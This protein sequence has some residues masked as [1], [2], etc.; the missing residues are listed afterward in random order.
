[1]T[2]TNPAHFSNTTVCVRLIAGGQVVSGATM[3]ATAH[4][5]TKDTDLGTAIT[6]ADGVAHTTF[7]IGGASSGFTVVVDGTIEGVPFSTSFTPQ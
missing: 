3:S 7:S 1:M 6:G 4:Y 5:K 2:V